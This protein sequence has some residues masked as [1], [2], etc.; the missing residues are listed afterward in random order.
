[1]SETLKLSS[2]DVKGWL[3]KET[4][5][6]FVPV[7]SRAQKFVDEMRRAIASL[8]DAS[9][10]LLESSQKEIEKRNMK[11]YGRARALNKLAHLFLDRMRQIKVPNQVTYDSFNAFVQETQKAF[12]VTDIDIR[13]WFSRISPFFILDRRKFQTVFEKA[14]ELLKEMTNFL[15]REYV[16]TK[17]LEETFQLAD[18]LKALEAQL[19]NLKQQRLKTENEK[20]HVD[21]EIAETQQKMDELKTR[22]AVSQLNQIATEIDTLTMEV[23]LALHYLQKPFIKLQALSLHGGGSGLLQEEVKKLDQYLQNPFAALATEENNYPLLR[24]ILQKTKRLM[25]DNKLKL[26]SDKMRKAEQTIDQILNKNSLANLQQRCTEATEKKTQLS[27]SAEVAK[28]KSDLSRLQEVIEK[29]EIRKSGIMA[30]EST[31]EQEYNE[32]LSKIQNHKSQMEKNILGFINRKVHI[33]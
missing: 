15:T 9:K 12:L 27:M 19:E 23:K 31:A 28:T 11:T 18:K 24:Q 13:N 3:E 30:E 10:M 32:I 4:A 1:M 21:R 25:A 26:K 22:G 14:K 29:L 33:K 20:A 16:Q 6:I 5:T 8:S 17:T 2:K 7:H